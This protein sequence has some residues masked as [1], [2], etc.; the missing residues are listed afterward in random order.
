MKKISW[1]AKRHKLHARV[2]IV[3]SFIFLNMLAFFT[4]QFLS[5]LG[6]FISEAFLFGCFFIFLIAFLAYPLRKWKE[7]MPKPLWYYRLQK[8]CDFI[9][10]AS[11][12][13]MIVCLSN[14]PESFF[15][16]YPKIKAVAVTFPSKSTAKHYK[17]IGD[18]Y[19]SLNDGKGN[20]I[21][22]K[23]RKRL[24]K[25]QVTGIKKDNTLSKGGKIALIIFSCLAAL[26]LL[27]L[28]AGLSCSLSCSGSDAAAVIVGIGGTALVVFLLI[29]A[30][31]A[32]NG[33]K[34]KSKMTAEPR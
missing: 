29:W 20:E 23:E 7:T 14:Q 16:F 3:V 6:I 18:F 21:K 15:Q 11:T 33:K 26:G 19:S 13:C 22:W 31:R 27:Y 9:L 1:W 5:Q 10:A 32:I 12:F 30:I 25:E 8:S 34:R 2:I 4:G 28:V 24:L 17:S